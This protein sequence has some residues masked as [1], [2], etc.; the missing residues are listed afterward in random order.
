MRKRH[1]TLVVVTLLA[2]LIS[3]ISFNETQQSIYNVD[4]TVMINKV[5]AVHS[6]LEFS[7]IH[8]DSPKLS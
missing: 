3:A 5:G 6:S 1:P 7:F 2:S 8:I 4:L